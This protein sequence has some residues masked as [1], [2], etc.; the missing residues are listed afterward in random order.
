MNTDIL[1]GLADL[2]LLA[3]IIIL[4]WPWILKGSDSIVIKPTREFIKKNE[5]VFSIFFIVLFALEQALLILLTDY[6]KDNAGFLRL[7]ISIFALVVMTTAS[8][9]KFVLETKRRYEKEAKKSI[10]KTTL[11]LEKYKKVVDEYDNLMGRLEEQNKSK[12]E[13]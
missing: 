13:Q 6:F 8:L 10:K 12:E 11:T 3:L 2:T 7:I 9:Q 4:A 1:L 5:G